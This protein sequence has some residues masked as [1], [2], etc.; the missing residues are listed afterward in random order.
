MI[1]R[2]FLLVSVIFLAGCQGPVVF[3]EPDAQ[4]KCVEEEPGSQT[5]CLKE[6]KSPKTMTDEAEKVEEKTAEFTEISEGF[7]YR[8]L[9]EGND[10]L[11]PAQNGDN[12]RVQY[13]GTFTNGKQFDSSYQNG[14]PFSFTLGGGQ[15]IQG[16]DQGVV[17]MLVGER[18][19]L[20]IPSRLGY[21]GR[22]VGNIPP[23]STLVFSIELVQNLSAQ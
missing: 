21:G 15:V 12:L 19:E 1:W 11:R 2:S 14:R 22:A 23:N 4:K 20:I 16:W 7:K 6:E 5:E 8:T 17:G 18:R 10:N 3:Q 13:I 9:K